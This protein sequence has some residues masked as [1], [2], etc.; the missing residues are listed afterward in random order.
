MTLY[1]LLERAE[2]EHVSQVHVSQCVFCRGFGSQVQLMITSWRHIRTSRDSSLPLH[3]RTQLVIQARSVATYN[4]AA[5][6]AACS[7]V[8]DDDTGV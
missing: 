4:D 3:E 1:T 5:K 2:A 8:L 7:R 6:T